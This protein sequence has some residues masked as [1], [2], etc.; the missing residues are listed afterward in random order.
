L[1][2]IYEYTY[3]NKISEYQNNE[4]LN[5]NYETEFEYNYD[6]DKTTIVD[7]LLD[8]GD[9]YKS[10]NYDQFKKSFTVKYEEDVIFLQNF[11]YGDLSD[12]IEWL[13]LDIRIKDLIFLERFTHLKELEILFFEDIE[14]IK[15]IE[16]LNNLHNLETLTIS[17]RAIPLIS[18]LKNLKKL[19]IEDPASYLLDFTHIGKF[20][21]LEYLNIMSITQDGLNILSNLTN[22]KQLKELVFTFSSIDDVSPLLNLTG[23]ERLDLYGINPNTSNIMSLVDSKSLKKI[24]LYFFSAEEYA[25]FFNNGGKM[26]EEKGIYVY[27]IEMWRR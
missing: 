17:Y 27:A 25:K 26:F 5:D 21:N 6:E 23:L 19:V 14:N 3:D 22:L 7:R 24:T 8:Y 18:N 11:S 16:A 1:C 12:Y 4:I 15:N 10:Y 2:W 9:Y 20:K 13:Y